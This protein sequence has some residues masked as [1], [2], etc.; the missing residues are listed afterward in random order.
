MSY[1]IRIGRTMLVANVIKKEIKGFKTENSVC[2]YFVGLNFEINSFNLFE[3][4]TRW[5]ILNL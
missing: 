3:E 5:C 4:K 1:A 2:P